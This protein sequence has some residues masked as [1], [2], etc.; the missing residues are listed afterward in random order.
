MP[1]GLILFSLILQSCRKEEDEAPTILI[2]EVTYI[3]ANTAG[4]Q[5]IISDYGSGEI[6]YTGVCWSKNSNPTTSN[7]KVYGTL[8]PRN[9][10]YFTLTDLEPV[11]NYYAR[12]F[13]INSAG[14]SYGNE[15]S[16]TTAGNPIG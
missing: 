11:T 5:G 4:C 8:G 12:A 3:Y 13:V 9:T 10:F 15:V 2:T 1:L 16:F 14:T 6:L 7:S